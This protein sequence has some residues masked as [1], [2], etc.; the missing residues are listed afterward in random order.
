MEE[1][2]FVWT[3]DAVAELMCLA[4]VLVVFVWHMTH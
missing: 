1:S 2:M 3:V 4:A